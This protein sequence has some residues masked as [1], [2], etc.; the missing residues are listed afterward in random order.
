MSEPLNKYNYDKQTFN[1]KS[2]SQE[3]NEQAKIDRLINMQERQNRI[4]NRLQTKQNIVANNNND[5][6]GGKRKS[7][8]RKS[9][10]VKKT[11]RHRHK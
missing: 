8:A 9:K 1:P 4:S 7:K 10:R 5:V 11:R 3:L 6:Y 2:K